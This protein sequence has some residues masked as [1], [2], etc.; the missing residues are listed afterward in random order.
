MQGS[1]ERS[2][3]AWGWR[4]RFPDEAARTGLTQLV[5]MVVPTAT[6]AARTLPPDEPALAEA[7]VG[8][9]PVLAAFAS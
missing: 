1:R 4:D 9:P 2:I 3:W 6:P 5:R 8:V 7:P